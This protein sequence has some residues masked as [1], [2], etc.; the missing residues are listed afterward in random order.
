MQRPLLLDLFCCQGGASAGYV[1]AGFDVVGVDI[2]PQPRYPFTF[3]QADAMTYLAEVIASGE[4]HRFAALHLSPPCQ[5]YSAL[6]SLKTRQY[7]DL[8]AAARDLAIASGLPWI[9]ENVATAPMAQGVMI[10]GTALGLN[11]R[12]HRLFDSSHLLYGPGPCR[13]DLDDINVYGHNAWNYRPRSEQWKRTYTRTNAKQCPVPV[14]QAKVAFQADWMTL[15]GLAEC[16]PPAYTAW[17]G[18]QLL[19][20]LPCGDLEV[21]A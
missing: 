9:L 10:C 13:H 19:A 7:P 8:L 17:L 21:S 5:E 4:I 2:A 18:R 12:R 3:I 20:T 15:A 1:R 14:A 11:V 6:K 16:I